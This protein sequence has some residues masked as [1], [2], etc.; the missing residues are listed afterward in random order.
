V[1]RLA[2]ITSHPI[3]YNAPLFTLL[4]E[5][6]NFSIKVFY[7]WGTSVLENKYDPGFGK[8]INWDIPLLEGYDYVL[9]KN[10]A[11]QPGSHHFKGIDNPELIKHI[12][13]WQADAIL[14]YG[15]AFKSH[16]QCLRYFH[17]KIP[18][19]FRGDSTLLDE[20][21]G[22]HFRKLIRRIFL[23]WVYRHVDKAL[24]VG[25]ENKKYFLAHGLLSDQ[26]IFAPH[27]IDNERFSEPDT[28]YQ[29]KAKSWKQSLQIPDQAFVYLFAGK[30]EPKKNPLLLAHA[31]M[32]IENSNLRLIFVGNGP[33][34]H[35]L[36]N[37][38]ENDGRIIFINFQNQQQMPVV[39]RLADIFVLPS[40]GPGETWGLAINE[41]MACGI[42]VLVSDKCGA[43]ADLVNQYT[44]WIFASGNKLALKNSLE[45]CFKNPLA[46]KDKGIAARSHINQYHYNTMAASIMQ[47]MDS[48]N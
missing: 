27:A 38:C 19:Y 25:I 42:P 21:K 35:Q 14:V 11:T 17:K 31:F 33:L 10:I 9:E 1:N 45:F 23:T 36:K 20:K 34:E 5:K 46:V 16:L 37:L 39:Y 44:G 41:A 13:E 24:Y 43:A 26:L 30:L 48:I 15:W 28:F 6:K 7:T 8:S 18:V 32:E 40:Q 29:E 2:I 4:K 22:F 47:L 3:Q 12:E